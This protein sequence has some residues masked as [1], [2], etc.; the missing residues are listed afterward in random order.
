[1]TE[2]EERLTHEYSK[3]AEQYAQEQKELSAQVESL[4]KQVRQLA[5]QYGQGQ[6]QL[7]GQVATLGEHV[8]QLAGQY[9]QEQTKHAEWIGALG[10]RVTTLTDAYD[11]LLENVNRMIDKT[12]QFHWV[13]IDPL[14][15]S[16]LY[17]NRRRAVFLLV[18]HQFRKGADIYV[19]VSLLDTSPFRPERLPFVRDDDFKRLQSRI[20]SQ[21]ARANPEHIN[22]LSTWFNYRK[23]RVRTTLLHDD[24]VR[25]EVLFIGVKAETDTVSAPQ[26][27]VGNHE[28]EHVAGRA[29]T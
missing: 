19:V 24:V 9:T 10:V 7:A 26:S 14:P 17:S 25:S 20:F 12:P 4:G 27:E 8:R 15:P 5:G 2:F 23:R 1:M 28:I 13:D 21:Q 22:D 16:P 3:L 18:P 11:S 6:T 29:S